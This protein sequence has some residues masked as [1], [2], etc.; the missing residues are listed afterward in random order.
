MF[1][2]LLCVKISASCN[3]VRVKL[4]GA[5]PICRRGHMGNKVVFFVANN[6]ERV[7]EEEKKKEESVF[8]SGLP[9]DFLQDRDKPGLKILFMTGHQE[10]GRQLISLELGV[11]RFCSITTDGYLL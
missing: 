6:Q 10:Q 5:V 4:Q 7:G 2:F 11:E 9:P 1:C 3:V 8:A